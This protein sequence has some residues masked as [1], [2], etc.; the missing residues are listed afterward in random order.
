MIKKISQKQILIKNYNFIKIKLQKDLIICKF[1]F[2]IK[3]LKTFKQ[4]IMK[5]KFLLNLSII[6]LLATTACKKDNPAPATTT[7]PKAPKT[8]KAPK[9]P[10]TP[11]APEAPETPETP[12]T[13]EIPKAPETP[14]APKTPKAP[15]GIL[16]NI[17]KGVADAAGPA[18]KQVTK[19]IINAAGNG[20]KKGANG[21]FKKAKK[22]IFNYFKGDSN[23]KEDDKRDDISFDGASDNEEQTSDE[24]VIE[25]ASDESVIIEESNDDNE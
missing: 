8:T 6:G 25:H 20:V 19:D 4:K 10:E 2:E 18:A 21:A 24:S 23:K 9:A 3:I 17:Q 7:T 22:G 15:T 14:K 1:V 5:M 16:T 13:P 12:E 11:E